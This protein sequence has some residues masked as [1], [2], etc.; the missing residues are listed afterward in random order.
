MYFLQPLSALRCSWVGGTALII[1]REPSMSQPEI[2][3]LA[4][5]LFLSLS[6]IFEVIVPVWAIRELSVCRMSA[7]LRMTASFCNFTGTVLKGNFLST[8]FNSSWNLPSGKSWIPIIFFIATISWKLFCNVLYSLSKKSPDP[9]PWSKPFGSLLNKP[10]SKS[11]LQA[12][13]ERRNNS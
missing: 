12:P 5:C 11:W 9:F 8:F 7:V 10:L 6:L 1:I 13:D 2:D 4:R 3:S